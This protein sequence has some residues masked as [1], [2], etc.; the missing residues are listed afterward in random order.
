MWNKNKVRCFAFRA[1]KVS[2]VIIAGIWGIINICKGNL[3]FDQHTTTILSTTAGVVGTMF[4]LTAAS[5]AFI[6][7]DL[8]SDSQDGR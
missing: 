6:W 3:R 8:R 5:Y 4:G 1:L 2:A 7:G